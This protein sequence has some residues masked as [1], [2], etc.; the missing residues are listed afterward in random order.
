MKHFYTIVLKTVCFFLTFLL[1]ITVFAVLSYTQNTF[2]KGRVTDATTL[3]PV[4]FAN[5]YFKTTTI[6]TTT[7]FEGYYELKCDAPSDSLTVSFVGYNTL[8]KAI[9][10]GVS[11]NLNFQLHPSMIGLTEVIIRP[12][13][14]PAI[15]LL[16]KVWANKDLHNINGLDAFSY[17][18]YT[19]TQ[20]YL[21]RLFKKQA[22]KDTAAGGIFNNF[23]VVAEES[24]MPAL[25]VYMSEVFSKNY[26]LRFPEREKVIIKAAQTNSLADIET[27]MLTQLVQKNTTYNFNENFVRIL[28]KNF[29]SPISTAGQFYYKYYLVDSLYIDGRYCYEIRVV[30]KRQEELT[31]SGTIWINDTTYALKRVSVEVGKGANLNFVERIKIQQDLEP[32]PSSDAWYPHKTRI[33]ADAIN[34]FISANIVNTAFKEERHP[35]SF[36]DKELEVADTAYS[37]SKATWE[38]LRPLMPDSIDKETLG[39]IDNLKTI[40][41]VRF[42]TALVNMSIKGYVNLGKIE[43]GPYLLLYKNNPVEGHRFRMGYR[44]NSALSEKW[45]SKGFL[46]YGTKD[47]KFKYNAQLERF[48]SRKHWTKIGVQYSEDVENLGAMDEFYSSSA[49]LSFASSFGGADKL[50]SIKVGRLWL[51]TDIFRGFTQKI[52]FKNKYYVPLSPDYY[53]AYYTNKEKTLTGS[54][55]TVSE[56]TLSSTYQ[57]KATFIVDKNERFPVA[58]RKAPAF[59]FNYT[60]GFKDVLGGNFNY[61]KASLGVKHNILLGS[62]GAFTYDATLSKCFSPLPYPLLTLFAANESFFRSERTFNLMRYGEFIADASAEVFLTYRQDGFIFDKLPLIKKLRLRSVAGANIAYGSFD[63]KRNGIYDA[64][65]NPEGILSAHDAKGNPI[66]H[67]NTLDKNKPYVEVSY[68]IENIVRVIRVDAIHRLSYLSA[69][70]EGEKPPKFGIKV[71]AVFRF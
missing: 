70:Q 62:L 53:F 64:Q 61:H 41:R 59:T 16:K 6:G 45:M 1:H 22:A 2:I 63:E 57:P 24:A 4:A 13:E 34:I 26:S 8:T 60:R 12:G 15:T 18:S 55:I 38:S 66:T 44:T 36:Y 19:K 3:E 27:G 29:V 14:N 56:L 7:D 47:E 28:D 25:P 65:T 46:A 10:Q 71:S 31:F 20:V 5:V 23:S 68:G 54:D 21:R 43:V 30:P 52:V 35:L 67:F 58:I 48:L 49:F 33:L 9:T 17:D 40:G 51:E 37:V 39:H 42:L 32:S 11:Q 69:N 50:N